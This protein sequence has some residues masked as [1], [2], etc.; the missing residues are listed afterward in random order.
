MGPWT[1]AT[2]GTDVFV[3]SSKCTRPG[4]GSD[5]PV[6]KSRGLIPASARDV[7]E[8][9]KDSDRVMD[10]N[11]MSIGREDQAVL[12][13]DS[14]VHCSETK[15]P[16]L[17]VTGEAK[18]MISKNQPPLVRK[19]LAFK[20][21]F[22]ARQLNSD[23]D[24]ET[25]GVAYITVG[26]SVWESPDG[27]ADGADNSTTRCEIMLTVNLVREITNENGEVW[28]ELTVI[29]HGISPGIP[30]FICKQLGL[31]AAENYIK[32]IRALFEK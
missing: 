12:T 26:R 32:D 20:T 14:N 7:V 22:Y 23:D 1:N 4:H 27:T 11:K 13:Q 8:L 19:P 10:Y 30:I 28:C 3:W 6:V 25:N 15:C 18:I 24:V 21:L 5:Y 9:I 29:T 2:S 17:G 31:L 16:E